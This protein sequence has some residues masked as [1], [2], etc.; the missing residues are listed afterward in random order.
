MKGS[1]VEKGGREGRARGRGW[2]PPTVGRKH[3]SDGAPSRPKAV[4]DII[5]LY[6]AEPPEGRAAERGWHLISVPPNNSECLG[7]ALVACV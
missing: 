7:F 4:Q 1:A 2:G 5:I 6:N 3:S